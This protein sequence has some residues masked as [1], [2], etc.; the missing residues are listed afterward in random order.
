MILP[1]L[2][3][4]GQINPSEHKRAPP[5]AASIDRTFVSRRVCGQRGRARVCLV[6]STRQKRQND[7]VSDES[8]RQPRL[9]DSY[10]P[11]A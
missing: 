11:A 6:L 8:R 3:P 5:H 9:A 7:T 4:Q 1:F 2:I 10:A